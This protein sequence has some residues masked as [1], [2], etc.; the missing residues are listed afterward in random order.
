MEILNGDV[1]KMD[2]WGISFDK[3]II[4]IVSFPIFIFFVYDFKG[5][6]KVAKCKAV[7]T[8]VR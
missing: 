6:I 1:P 8:P 3:E 4:L 2:P 5:D 7:V